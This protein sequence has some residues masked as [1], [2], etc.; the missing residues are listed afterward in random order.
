M[1]AAHDAEWR[2]KVALANGWLFNRENRRNRPAKLTLGGA[3][4]ED[5]EVLPAVEALTYEFATLEQEADIGRIRA[6]WGEPS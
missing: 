4:P 6:K 5:T 3:L 2:A 1:K